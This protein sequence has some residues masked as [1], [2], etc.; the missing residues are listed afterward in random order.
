MNRHLFITGEKGIGKSTLLKKIVEREITGSNEKKNISGFLTKRIEDKEI[1]RFMVHLLNING[2]FENI[3]KPSKENI[4]FYCN[5]VNRAVNSAY[6]FDVLGSKALSRIHDKD[7]VIMDELGPSESRALKFK[8]AIFNVLDGKY[9]NVTV[10]GVL[11][12]ADSDF[13]TEISQRKDVK[14]IKMTIENRN[15]LYNKL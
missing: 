15:E 9:G 12:K 1:K 3:E 5:D 8:T 2:S 7:I 13:L 6:R 4:L 11:Q 10:Y 14:L